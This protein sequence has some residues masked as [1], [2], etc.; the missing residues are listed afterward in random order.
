MRNPKP[1]TSGK[2]P[3]WPDCTEEGEPKRSYRNARE[4]INALGIICSND[5]F[6]DRMLVGGHPIQQWAGELSDAAIVV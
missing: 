2:T 5:E 6:H 3:V 1:K 4:A